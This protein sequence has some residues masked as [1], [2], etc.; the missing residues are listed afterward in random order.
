MAQRSLRP[1]GA[2]DGRARELT[3]GALC[4]NARSPR[5]RACTN[6]RAQQSPVAV[7]FSAAA[8]SLALS[9]AKPSLFRGLTAKQSAPLRVA[10]YRVD[11]L[12]ENRVE[13]VR[14]FHHEEV[15]RLLHGDDFEVG[16]RFLAARLVHGRPE[17]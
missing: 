14:C 5:V 13:A 9:L 12:K 2:R 10:R 15:A 3:T 11:F 4:L 1:R 17:A 16:Q 7:K 6:T 8:R